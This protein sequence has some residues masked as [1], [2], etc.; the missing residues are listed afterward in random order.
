MSKLHI[1]PK[2]RLGKVFD[3][4]PETAGWSY[5]GFGLYHLKAGEIHLVEYVHMDHTDHLGFR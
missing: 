2:G 1:K 3:V 5:V 4:T